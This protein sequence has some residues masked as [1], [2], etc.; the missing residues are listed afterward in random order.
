MKFWSDSFKEGDKLSKKFAFGKHSGV[1][2]FDFSDNRNPHFAWADLPQNTLSLALIVHDA[3]APVTLDNVNKEEKNV[4]Y[5][6]PRQNFYHWVLVDIDLNPGYILEGEYSDGVTIHGK[7]GPQTH[8][9]PRCGVNDY[10]DWFKGRK[11]MEGNYF[12]YDG[13]APPWNDERIHHY[14][15]TLYALKEKKCPVRGV[16]NGSQALRAIEN[17]ILD[18][19]QLSA[20]YT[21]NPKAH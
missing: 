13:P 21:I 8:Q 11:D 17:L 1:V 19:A 16:F 4:S 10:T 2:H 12:G 5:A 15:F 20:L 3:D 6:S 7:L 18:K 14:Y 9:G